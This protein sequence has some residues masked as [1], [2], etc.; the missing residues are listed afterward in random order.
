[1]TEMVFRKRLLQLWLSC[2]IVEA[3][4]AR[5]LF[6][7]PL[8]I[9]AQK[10]VY[11]VIWLAAVL[12]GIA[13]YWRGSVTDSVEREC[14]LAKA[15]FERPSTLGLVCSWTLLALMPTA[16]GFGI[17]ESRDEISW[18]GML[19][20]VAGVLANLAFTGGAFRIV[21]NDYLRRMQSGDA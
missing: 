11:S 7:S 5:L 15:H 8:Q 20:F 16:L 6:I 19:G 4:V 10:I 14:I 2:T 21:R 1:M 3:L 18:E 9:G 17:W 12:V 13:V